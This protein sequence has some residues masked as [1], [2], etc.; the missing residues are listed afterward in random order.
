MTRQTIP[1]AVEAVL[2]SDLRLYDTLKIGI[3]NYKALARHIRKQVE[4]LAGE[5]TTENAIAMA[6]QRT[7]KK[8]RTGVKKLEGYVDIF[9][10]SRLQMRDNI[11]ILYLKKP[12]EIQKIE[13]GFMVVIKG[14]ESTTI[15]MDD[16]KAGKLKIPKE[17]IVEQRKDLSAIILTSPK[18]IV[19]TPGVIAHLMNALGVNNINVVEVTSSFNTTYLL[20]DKKDS[21]EAVKIVRS[22]IE[23]SKKDQ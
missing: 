22:L 19:D 17:D 6:L 1:M 10:S 21:L 23:R 12:P 13:K 14:I 3:V 2:K 20:V 8:I 4:T 5:K 16:E 15:F 7:G 18:E 9:A 11:L